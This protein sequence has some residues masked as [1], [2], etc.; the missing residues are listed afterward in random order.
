MGFRFNRHSALFCV[1]A[2]T[3][4]LMISYQNFSVPGAQLRKYLPAP[5]KRNY[6][7]TTVIEAGLV[8]A[9]APTDIR[10]SAPARPSAYEQLNGQRY[11]SLQ[12]PTHVTSL[13]GTGTQWAER[14]I[15][16]YLAEH[17]SQFVATINHRLNR[18]LKFEE[19]ESEWPASS[20]DRGN[21]TNDAESGRAPA[22]DLDTPHLPPPQNPPDFR[23][24]FSI[25][26]YRP[27]RVQLT[28][29]N[30]LT[31]GFHGDTALSCEV[32]SGGSKFKIARPLDNRT[33]V[34]VSHDTIEKKNSV[35]LTISW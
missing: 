8:H 29:A 15:R 33:Q 35:H 12:A 16:P 26:S 6:N 14:E 2:T 30:E 17:E 11:A 21:D 1:L 23:D 19:I 34:D 20:D 13:E 4:L 24:L 7:D 32:A 5:V 9:Q 27:T 28:K 10:E 3:L 18:M 25:K 31:V 22:G